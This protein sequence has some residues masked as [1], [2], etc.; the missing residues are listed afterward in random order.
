MSLNQEAVDK[1]KDLRSQREELSKK[2][3]ESAK[4]LFKEATSTLF[5]EFPT[6]EYFAWRQYTPYFNDGETC[7][8]SANVDD[9]DFKFTD[10]DEEREYFGL[11]NLKYY[12]GKKYVDQTA[13][14]VNDS[15]VKEILNFL[16]L[17]DD[18]DYLGMFGDHAKVVVT[19]TGV[20]T[21]NYE[22]D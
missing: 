7:E 4:I 11:L 18:D 22:H 5:Q 12:D 19:K 16:E 9:I 10:E 15:A 13:L 17:F 2:I 6:L 3:R 20:E 21:E 1:L 8:F 14:S